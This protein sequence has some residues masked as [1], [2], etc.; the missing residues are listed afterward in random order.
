MIIRAGGISTR[1]VKELLTQLRTSRALKQAG[2]HRGVVHVSSEKKKSTSGT[3]YALRF[4]LKG[5]VESLEQANELL[6]T[7][8]DLIGTDIS[9]LAPGA[10]LPQLP[11]AVS[12]QI[13][14]PSIASQ[15]SLEF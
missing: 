7:S 4:K 3:A 9:A 1:A 15:P 11:K 13:S 14:Q 5:L 8:S 10:D 12:T 6:A 2:M